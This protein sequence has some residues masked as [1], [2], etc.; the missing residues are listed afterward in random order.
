VSNLYSIG[1]PTDEEQ[2]YL[3]YMNRSRANPPAE[4]ARL[5]TTTDPDVL[6][7]Y[8]Y[9]G[10]D[11]ALLQSQFNT[12][13]AAPPLAMN[14]QLLA[15]A[16]L[17]SGDM[18]TN[19]Y[20]SHYQTNGGVVLSPWNRINNQ[21]Y[22][23]STA[24]ENIFA[25]AKSVW[26]GHAGFNVDW[27]VGPGG[28]QTPPGHRENIADPGLREVGVG[29]RD[30][31][32]GSVGPQLVTQD[33]GTLQNA[34]PLI[35]GVAY[36]DFSG[37]GFY[38]LGEGIGGVTVSVSGSSFYAVTANSGG[39][40]IP[41]T[42]NG[43]YT[44]TFS[45]SGLTTTQRVAV[46]MSSSN[47]KVDFTPVY[48]PPVISGPNPAGLNQSNTYN[49][50]PVGGATAYQCEQ[51]PLANYTAI[52]GAENGLTNVT[53]V[54]S[55]GYSV[56]VSDVVASGSYA[57]H[58][59][60]PDAAKQYLT[61]NAVLRPAANSQWT[62]A[63]RL[64]WAS[65]NQ[66][67]R[68]QISTNGG[69]TWQD[70]WTQAGTGGSG[71]AAFSRITNSLSPYAGQLLQVRF[72]YDFLGGTYFPQTSTGIA[73]Y[74]DDIAVSNAEQLLNASTNNLAAGNS[75][76]FYPANTNSCLLL[77]RAQIGG[78]ALPWGPALRVTVATPAPSLQLVSAPVL[79]TN[80]VQL[81]FTVA[82]YRAGMSFQLL[83]T[84]VA[85]GPWSTNG[86]AS[87]QTLIANSKFRATASTGG[88]AKMFYRVK[89]SY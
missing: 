39:Y 21:G 33:F 40:A 4:G 2:L 27:G 20:Q 54:S 11:L 49:F 83:Q 73:L 75:F 63:K 69:G 46:V 51:A 41:V 13:L 52:Q 37:N 19:N 9:F 26:H 72:V 74:L 78:R 71:D 47:V 84:S 24:A 10:V 79:A 61:L 48:S 82:N 3:E 23:F 43:N 68:A 22:Y 7:A 53:V 81:D 42:T 15:S 35:T 65:S 62:F 8:S 1:Q 64:S 6:S 80:Q 25:Y 59:A 85:S 12:I 44:V 38:D 31:V 18:Y 28:M 86:T 76:T 45:A 77:V 55:A 57:F 50:T 32:N 34:T 60:Q 58:L 56:I 14:A 36:Y 30:G 67:A 17:H 29:V 88:A 5:A 66:V 70:V 87:F 89:A 16:R